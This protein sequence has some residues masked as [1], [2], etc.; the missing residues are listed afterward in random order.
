MSRKCRE[1]SKI[2]R[3]RRGASGSA[4]GGLSCRGDGTGDVGGV[5]KMSQGCREGVAK[6]SQGC[7]KGVL[8]E[9]MALEKPTI[10]EELKEEVYGG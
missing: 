6:V 9:S 2:F 5:T 8:L 1:V 10:K 3:L 7:R 4:C